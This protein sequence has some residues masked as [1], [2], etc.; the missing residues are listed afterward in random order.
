MLCGNPDG[1]GVWGGDGYMWVYDWVPSLFT[2]NDHSVINR[3]YPKTKWKLQ[4]QKDSWAWCAAMRVSYNVAVHINIEKRCPCLSASEWKHQRGGA[5]WGGPWGGE[6]GGPRSRE[7]RRRLDVS[8][9]SSWLW[10]G[11]E[12]IQPALTSDK[13]LLLKPAC[14]FWSIQASWRQILTDPGRK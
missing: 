8:W 4:N 1:R 10:V 12:P 5:V 2:W 7:G 3:P 11:L 13:M 9:S 14:S 6:G